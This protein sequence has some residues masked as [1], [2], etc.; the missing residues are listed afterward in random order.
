MTLLSRP[1]R[2]TVPAPRRD[3]VVTLEAV[4]GEGILTIR[5]KG[6]RQGYS[7]SLPGLFVLL[8]R[9]AADHAVAERKARRKANRGAS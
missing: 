7:V 1:V 6:R 8:A 3:L 4:A 2:R 9:R 5:E